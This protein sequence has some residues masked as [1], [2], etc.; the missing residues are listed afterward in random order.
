M[1][2]GGEGCNK[3]KKWNQSGKRK[4]GEAGKEIIYR[5]TI[6]VEVKD[7][8]DG[9]SKIRSQADFLVYKQRTTVITAART[10]KAWVSRLEPNSSIRT[11]IAIPMLLTC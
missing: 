7:R 2:Q 1:P 11:Y 10:E 8:G 3:K 9:E 5:K 4:Q 6:L